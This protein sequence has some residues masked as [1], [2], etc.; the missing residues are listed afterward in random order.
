MCFLLF[1]P[2]CSFTL[3][4]LEVKMI[5]ILLLIMVSYDDHAGHNLPR[6]RWG[7]RGGGVVGKLG[8]M[9]N[10]QS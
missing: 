5:M 6:L 1:P 8:V 9:I 3:M 4:G 7:A 2:N 10:Y